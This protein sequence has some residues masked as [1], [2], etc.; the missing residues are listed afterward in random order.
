MLLFALLLLCFQEAAAAS[1]FL[2]SQPEIHV[3]RG[4]P[5]INT[6]LRRWT[7]NSLNALCST[8]FHIHE[9]LVKPDFA[10]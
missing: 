4:P 5:D 1:F 9:V 3:H 2:L 8:L 6:L 7:V 10:L